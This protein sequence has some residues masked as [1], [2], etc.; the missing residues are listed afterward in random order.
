MHLRSRISALLVATAAAAPAV[1][2]EAAP[3]RAPSP[4]IAG[5]HN[6]VF[7]LSSP[8]GNFF[9]IPSGRVQLDAA[10]Y[11]GDNIS[12]N[13]PGNRIFLRRIR[14]EV[15]GG[16]LGRYTFMLA[17]D[18]AATLPAAP[19]F[20]TDN[21]LDA[22][23]HA[24]AHIQVGQ[25]DAP[26]MLENRTSDKYLDLMERALAVR[27]FGVP[28]NKEQ[29]VMLWGEDADRYVYYSVGVFNGDGQNRGNP[30][31]LFDVMG[32]VFAHPLMGVMGVGG[33]F[34]NLQIGG[35]FWW[36]QRSPL[37]NYGYPAI[38]SPTGVTFWG[39]SANGS[40]TATPPVGSYAI[41]PDATQL[42]FAGELVL[43]IGNFDLHAEFVYRNNQTR[44]MEGA[45]GVATTALTGRGVRQGHIEGLGYYVQLAYWV[46]LAGNVDANHPVNGRAGYENP[47]AL[48]LDRPDAA[49]QPRG[50][51]LLVRW[52]A[53]DARYT[54]NDRFDSGT[55]TTPDHSGRI[56]VNSLELGAN[57]WATKHVRFSLAYSLYLFPDAANNL[58]HGPRIGA[59][60]PA[61]FVDSYH[62]IMARVGLAL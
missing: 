44:E 48:R 37:V 2:Q 45:P 8:G 34:Q 62:E 11:A 57:Y 59:A 22:R 58:A 49:V 10:L 50:L 17:G 36:G 35:S 43:P 15:L 52:D 25:Y 41:V 9:L 32:R 5:W 6:D 26:F 30:D 20:A 12:D 47:P 7:F 29:G 51:Q 54:S 55:A 4:G 13:T 39:T 33:P 40:A 28:T 46:P 16:F 1:A 24:L 27:A 18:F 21:L 3:A 42:G 61:T 14:A 19:P 56:A 60:A 38:T 53:I 31:N 23:L